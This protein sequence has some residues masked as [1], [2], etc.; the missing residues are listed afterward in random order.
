MTQIDYMYDFV[1]DSGHI[2]KINNIDVITLGHGFD[3][4]DVVK[5]DY[6]GDKIIDDLMKHESWDSGY[7]CLDKYKFIR[8]EDMKIIGLEY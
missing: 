6:F 8:G 4:N 1:L 3:F 7:I 5:H 2:V